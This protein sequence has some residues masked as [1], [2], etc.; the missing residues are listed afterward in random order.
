[1]MEA[2]LGGCSCDPPRQTGVGASV[3]VRW[4]VEGEPAVKKIG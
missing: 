2:C 3:R 4:G 1:M